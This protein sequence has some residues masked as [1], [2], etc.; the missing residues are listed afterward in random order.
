MQILKAVEEFGMLK[1]FPADDAARKG[2]MRLLERMVGTSEQLD[3]LVGTM[4]DQVGEWSGP[5]ELRGV[6]CS[7]FS[8]RDGIDAEGSGSFSPEALESRSAVEHEAAKQLGAGASI[9]L[10]P[11]VRSIKPEVLLDVETKLMEIAER[12]QAQPKPKQRERSEREVNELLR[13]MGA[14]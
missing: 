3:W 9:A 11:A 10:L 13:Q 6:F 2:V 8:P 14:A 5:V 7:R 12:I 1:Y 4:I